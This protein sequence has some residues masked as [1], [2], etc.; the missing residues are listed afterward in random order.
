[1]VFELIGAVGGVFARLIPHA[2]DIWKDDREGKRELARLE[3]EGRLERFRGLNR[4]AEIAAAS[5]AQLAQTGAASAAELAEIGARSDAELDGKWGDGLLEAM[6]G[7]GRPT[8]DKWLDRL[9]VSVRPILTYWWCIVIYTLAKVCLVVSVAT[10]GGMN[11][12]EFAAIIY[13]DF[14]RSVVASIIGFWFV[15]RVLRNSRGR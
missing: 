7:Q 14:D 6:R 11:P 3:A 9:N 1:M 4:V 5:E 12:A 13:T 2:M 10:G 8:D 15:D